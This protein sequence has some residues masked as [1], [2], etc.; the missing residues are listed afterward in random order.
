[1][2]DLVGTFDEVKDHDSS[3]IR[4]LLRMAVFIAPATAPAIAS[5][6]DTSNEAVIP[7]GYESVGILDKE[8]ALTVTPSTTVSEVSGYGYG[9]TLR[10]DIVSKN[11]TVAFTM[12]ESR[13]QAFELYYGIDLSAVV[14]TPE[15]GGKNELTFDEPDRPDTLYWRVLCLGA[16]G[17]GANTLYIADYYPR[18]TITDVAA[19]SSSETDPR[20]YGVTL[21]I[22]VDT[23]L[24]TAH[25]QFWAG[26]GLTTAK[27]TAMGFTR[28][29]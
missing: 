19:I 4:K 18:A 13:R 12:I 21:G 20:R 1:M 6:V 23:D 14:A 29:V 17:D 7:D 15:A 16:D 3:N 11:Q 2:A 22:D 25:R 10:R 27:I 24:G 9:T 8:N 26:P 28:A 5:L